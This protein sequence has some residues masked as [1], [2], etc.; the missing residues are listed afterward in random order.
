MY[1]IS[2]PSKTLTFIG[3]IW[4]GLAMMFFAFGAVILRQMSLIPKEDLIAEGMLELEADMFLNVTS[5]L[6]IVFVIVGMILF[7]VFL[8]NVVLFTKLIK[9]SLTP[10]QAKNLFVYQAIWGGVSLIFNTI[11]GILYLM[12][13]ISAQSKEKALN[14]KN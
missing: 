12:S 8:V 1:K 6:N 3:L 10:A 14:N 13:A 9:G 7:V 5:V 4:E 11:T 2:E